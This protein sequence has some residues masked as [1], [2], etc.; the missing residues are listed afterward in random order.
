MSRQRSNC[1][2][3]TLADARWRYRRREIA[4]A[5]EIVCDLLV[6]DND[7]GSTVDSLEAYFLP[8]AMA[9]RRGR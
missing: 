7:Y 4:R 8:F 2:N 9:A 5:R 1:S 3:A 6:G